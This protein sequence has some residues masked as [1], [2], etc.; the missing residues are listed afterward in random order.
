MILICFTGCPLSFWL[1]KLL[2]DLSFSELWWVAFNIW[3]ALRRQN[4]CGQ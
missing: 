4:F 2:S 3:F 1:A